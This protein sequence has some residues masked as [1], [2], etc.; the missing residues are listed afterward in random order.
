MLLICKYFPELLVVLGYDNETVIVSPPKEGSVNKEN[1][2]KAANRQ[3]NVEKGKKAAF[4]ESTSDG[5]HTEPKSVPNN[6]T[7]A[8]DGG[9]SE[10][11]SSTATVD[12]DKTET[13]SSDGARPK[14]QLIYLS[15]IIGFKVIFNNFSL[16]LKIKTLPFQVNFSDFPKGNHG[17]FLTLVTLNTDPPQ[18]CHGS[19]KTIEQSH[20]QA[21][22]TTLKLLG[23]LGLDNV[24]PKPKPTPVAS[25]AAPTALEELSTATAQ[26]SKK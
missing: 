20:D 17:E 15:R 8:S 25:A 5:N 19:G 9:V 24:K 18:L 22:S 7:Q 21:A 3:E 2:P 23:E 12:E 14:D 10:V 26:P 1:N 11:S 4:Q 6:R 13:T 16:K